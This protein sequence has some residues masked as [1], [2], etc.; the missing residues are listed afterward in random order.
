MT[1]R[2]V[3]ADKHNE[4]VLMIAFHV[5]K[6][7][8]N[9]ENHQIKCLDGKTI[10]GQ[11]E[12][13]GMM[14]MS[15][16]LPVVMASWAHT[17]KPSKRTL[18]HVCRLFCV[19]YPLIK[20]L[21]GRDTDWL[22]WTPLCVK[23]VCLSHVYSWKHAVWGIQ[24]SA[25]HQ[26]GHWLLPRQMDHPQPPCSPAL[27]S[28]LTAARTN[29][30]SQSICCSNPFLHPPPT[31]LR[32]TTLPSGTGQHPRLLL[33]PPSPLLSVVTTSGQDRK[34]NEDAL[35]IW[36]QRLR[37]VPYHRQSLQQCWKRNPGY[38]FSLPCYC[39]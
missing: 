25:H 31:H 22:P 24:S 21:R 20:L 5:F 6:K 16:F 34:G 3:W 2:Q 27:C 1:E 23:G 8:K 28:R 39:Y 9:G 35:C 26:S 36:D 7:L 15:A 33:L 29:Y 11:E 13:L 30:I 38:L 19:N 37:G 10:R 4:T 17:A 18:L 14:N 12:T 32:M